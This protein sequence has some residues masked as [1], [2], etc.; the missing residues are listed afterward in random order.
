[1]TIKYAK[2]FWKSY[3]KLS[4]K[5]QK[6]IKEV[7]ALF[8]IDHNNRVLK[9][10]KLKGGMKGRRAISAGGDLRLIFKEYKNYTVVLFLDVG[11]HNQVY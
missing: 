7:I 6:K 9:N 2:S 8:Q 3:I 4:L 5:R 1:M 11:T 10:H